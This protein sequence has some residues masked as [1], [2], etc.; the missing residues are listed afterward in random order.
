[1]E[2]LYSVLDCSVKSTTAEIKQKYRE[3]A[4][5]THPDS[6]HLSDSVGHRHQF[7]K[8][9]HA[10]KILSDADMRRE[11]DN[12]WHQLTLLQEFPVHDSVDFEAFDELDE[13]LFSYPCRCGDV[14]ILSR[15]DVLLKFSYASC[16]SCSLCLNVLYSDQEELGKVRNQNSECDFSAKN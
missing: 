11:Y 7:A 4:R 12:R 15:V 6:L 1:M 8:I 9:S 5:L 14:F 16:S 10:Y 13:Q 2:D 3:L